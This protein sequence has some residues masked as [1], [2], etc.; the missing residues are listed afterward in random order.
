MDKNYL[1]I[2][3]SSKPA[4]FGILLIVFLLLY[5]LVPHNEGNY[6][7]RLPSLLGFIPIKLNEI[8][9]AALYEWFPL[10]VWDPIFEM[11]EE[12]AAFRE[13]TKSISKGLLFLITFVRELL[14]GGDKI[15]DVFVSDAWLKDNDWMTWPALPWTAA[16]VGAFLLGFQLG[17]IRLALLGGIGSLYV[18]IFGNWVPSIQTLSFVLITT[19][20]CFVLGLSF[21]IWGYLDRK[22]E[23]ALQP[24]LNVMQTMPQF[25]YLVPIIA[26][27]GLGDHAG[28]IATIVIAT[29]PMIRNTILGLKRI[30]PEVVE[31]GLMSGCTKTQLLF[32]V[33]IPTARRDI[34]NGVNTVIMQCLAMVV[35]ASF[36]GAKGLGLNL[37]IALNSLKIGKAAEA[38]FCIVLI[39]V[40][41]DRFTK[42]WAN[43]Q[44]DYFENLT[45]F[46]RYKLLIIFGTSILIFSIIAFI[47][48]GYFDKI[49]YL[50][51]IPI[52][53][54][55]TFAHYIDA[56]VDWV[57][58]TF[59]YSLN[60]FNKFFLTEVLGPMKKAYLGMPVVATLTLTMGVAYII[61]GIRTSL[62]VGGMMLFI[63][64]SKYWGRALITMYMATFAVIMASLN[65]I[66][67]GSIFAQTERGSK[68]ILS[69][70]DFFET[71]PSFVYLIPVIFLFNITDTSVLIAAIV[72][73]TVPATRYTVWGLNSVPLSLHEA[74]TM[75][76]VSRIQ[77]W[78]NI[79]IPLAFPTIMLGVNQTVVF[80]LQMVILGALIGT[81]DLGQ[82]IF[83]ALSRAQDGPGVAIT[84][85]LFVSLMAI[86][87]DVIVR[88]W[89]EE[90]KKAL[91]LA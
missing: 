23:T 9:Y 30:S 49:N 81:E 24:V 27:F 77:R 72:Y 66:I 48:N 13:F 8:I 89:A 68:I 75:S 36:V 79:E 21:G 39:A 83:G 40:I 80:T 32:K 74:G 71:F 1:N 29:P 67:V 91:G 25:A 65:G 3:R 34:L 42:A 60:S 64:M 18:S 11:Y 46:Q 26:L 37:K 14:L 57:W 33:L 85:G 12:K 41:L 56:A 76:G 6:F 45:F 62:L 63:A 52:E 4:Q 43:K 38:G 50:Y 44:V 78:T 15:I 51:V 7:W 16:T 2:I 19:P 22:V 55:F 70:C 61:G 10:K 5:N 58:E 17:G 69:V 90:R 28:S 86:S 73:A 84:L 87:V 88:K 59:F 53:K 54:G 20:I 35:I 82:L 31:A 47:A